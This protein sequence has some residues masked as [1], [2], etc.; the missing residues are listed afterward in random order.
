[1]KALALA[2]GVIALAAPAAGAAPAPPPE[3]W[4][5][6]AAAPVAS[7]ET[8]GADLVRQRDTLCAP[9]RGKTPALPAALRA[10]QAIVVAAVGRGA[11]QAFERSPTARSP[12]AARGAAVG[13]F[14]QGRATGAL[15][16]LLRLHE[17]APQDPSTLSSIAATLNVLG[18]PRE[19]LAV[20]QAA[21]SMR[22]TPAAAMGI[23]GRAMLRSNEGQALV[24]VGRYAAAERALREAVRL[25]PDLSEAKA[26][27]AVALLCQEQDAEAVRFYRLARY[28]RPYTLVEQTQDPQHPSVPVDG[29]I[30]DLSRGVDG[31]FPALRIPASWVD[32]AQGPANPGNADLLAADAGWSAR[33]AQFQQRERELRDAIDWQHLPSLTLQRFTRLTAAIYGARF[34]PDIKPL[35]D[36]AWSVHGELQLIYHEYFA[37]GPGVHSKLQDL[38]DARPTWPECRQASPAACTA[39]WQRE[40]SDLNATTHARWLPLAQELDRSLRALYA[41]RYRRETALAANIADPRLRALAVVRIQGNQVEYHQ[42][43]SE[44]RS[45]ASWLGDAGCPATPTGAAVK[46][47]DGFQQEPDGGCAPFL[48]GVRFAVKLGPYVKLGANCEQVTLEVAGKGDFLWIG[49]FAEASVDFK[50]GTGTVFA[51]GKAAAKIPE[52]NVGVSAKEGIYATFGAT[53]LRDIGMRVSTA[54]SFGL[55][56]G[57]TV[58]MKGPS[59]QI[60]F[61]SQTIDF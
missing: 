56:S 43:I 14:A 38:W 57:P 15:L 23:S 30:F 33:L 55:A 11:V 20:A 46:T 6:A 12:V 22:G 9:D 25:A 35:D 26:N 54:G 34:Q 41:A 2:L 47:D 4:S 44:L 28:R 29:E 19:A 21:R 13:L 49:P 60:S 31:M 5:F 17:L 3:L 16:A 58:D 51:G 61:V 10:A 7:P 50:R 48:K 8:V 27:L 39:R 52:T 36:H 59:Y 1:V 18:R 37:T 42:L 53:G 45:W 40:C 32:L 24:G